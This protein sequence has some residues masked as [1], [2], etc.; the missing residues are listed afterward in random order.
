MSDMPKLSVVIP[1]YDQWDM[2]PNMLNALRHQSLDQAAFHV[3]VVAN[4]PVPA[5]FDRT[6]LAP[7]VQL[8]DCLTAGSYAAR[9]VGIS[10]CRATH[11]VF[12]DADCVPE[13]D[14]LD[15]ISKAVLQ[16]PNMLLAGRISMVPAAQATLWSTYDE[17]RGIPQDRY[18][19]NGYGACA[20]L[21]VPRVAIDECGEFDAARL[22][23]GDAALCRLAATKGYPITYLDGAVVTHKARCSFG[24]MARKARRIRGGQVRNGVL[25]RRLL[26]IFV[27]L[28]PPA[29]ETWRFV[30]APVSLGKRARAV[31]GLYI[32]WLVGILE[33][34]RL[35][36][37]ASPERR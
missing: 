15:V 36:A 2:L 34:I 10:V 12:T 23:G 6:V 18:V 4:E 1:V 35:L 13:P 26:W 3:V 17:L 31:L 32:L 22:S 16:N 27:G 19:R 8:K 30:K 9:N 28:F 24:E 7:N 20:N 33:T 11:I 25:K 29:R 37:G 21:C 5:Q 14:W